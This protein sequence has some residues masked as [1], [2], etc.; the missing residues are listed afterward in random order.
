M[1]YIRMALERLREAGGI[2]KGFSE[3]VSATQWATESRGRFLS[4]SMAG[5]NPSFEKTRMGGAV[6]DRW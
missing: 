6:E 5:S 1:Q 3:P 4:K 2:H